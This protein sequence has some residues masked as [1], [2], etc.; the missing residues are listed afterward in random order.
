MSDRL[1]AT[2]HK[3][4][5]P[6]ILDARSNDDADGKLKLRS[7]LC[8]IPRRKRVGTTLVRSTTTLVV[9]TLIPS[10]VCPRSANRLSVDSERSVTRFY[11]QANSESTG[12][13]LDDCDYDPVSMASSM[14]VLKRVRRSSADCKVVVSL[15][16]S[17][18]F[19]TRSRVG[20]ESKVSEFS[21]NCIEGAGSPVRSPTSTF[22]R[23][24]AEWPPSPFNSSASITRRSDSAAPCLS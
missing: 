7:G 20:C 15:Y 16:P 6:E 19:S 13:Q 11:R 8:E 9:S 5:T 10:G 2:L 4:E 24:R 12:N 23:S 1:S 3:S 21:M 18:F 22:W 17:S 14:S